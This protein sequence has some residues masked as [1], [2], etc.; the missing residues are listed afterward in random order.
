[1]THCRDIAIRIFA[2]ERSV[3]SCWSVVNIF[4]FLILMSYTPLCYVRNV[5]RDEK[6]KEE[7]MTVIGPNY[8]YSRHCMTIEEEDDQRTCGKETWR[9]K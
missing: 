6:N 5:V 7:M 1:M 8:Q 9:K 3:I 2:N 4:I